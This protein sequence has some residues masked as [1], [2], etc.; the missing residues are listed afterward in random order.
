MVLSGAHH[1]FL[2]LK[3]CIIRSCHP[4]RRPDVPSKKDP[5]LDPEAY[6]AIEIAL[7]IPESPTALLNA[8]NRKNS[9]GGMP[10]RKSDQSR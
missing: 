10:K 2:D 7:Q 8:S 4:S 6:V 5:D 3:L 9:N 1:T